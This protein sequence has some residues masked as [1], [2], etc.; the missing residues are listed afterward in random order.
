M[1]KGPRIKP[2]GIGQ[3]F[4]GPNWTGKVR[5]VYTSSCAHCGIP[6]EF[7]SKRK[8]MEHVDLCFGC[9]RLICLNCYGKPCETQEAMCE[10]VEQE[11]KLQDKLLRA[12]WGCY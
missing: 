7:E 4:E 8:M 3:Y 12:A 1:P 2:G 6:T 11:A 9:M 10:R 5:E